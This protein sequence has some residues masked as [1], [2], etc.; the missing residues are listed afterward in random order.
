MWWVQKC[1]RTPGWVPCAAWDDEWSQWGTLNTEKITEAWR[2]TEGRYWANPCQFWSR[3][4]LPEQDC[5]VSE[6]PGQHNPAD[7]L[8]VKYHAIYHV[9][10]HV[11]SWPAP[12]DSCLES[13]GSP[14]H[15]SVTKSFGSAIVELTFSLQSSVFRCPPSPLGTRLLAK[16]WLSSP[17]VHMA[18]VMAGICSSQAV[19]ML[20]PIHSLAASFEGSRRIMEWDVLYL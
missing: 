7:I 18:W 2:T 12:V 16:I 5:I 4:T 10:Y 15:T 20:S 14:S 6:P 9:I 1:W 13:D 3:R 19:R 17:T 8:Y 11:I